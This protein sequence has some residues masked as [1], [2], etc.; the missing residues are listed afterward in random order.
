MTGR[1]ALPLAS[2][3]RSHIRG[4]DLA[5][6]ITRQVEAGI[7]RRLLQQPNPPLEDL[8]RGNQLRDSP[9]NVTGHEEV[10]GR[11]RQNTQLQIAITLSFPTHWL[12]VFKAGRHD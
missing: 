2:T 6:A 7:H 11:P 5:S 1:H 3:A 8:N 9:D 12:T 10:R 4:E